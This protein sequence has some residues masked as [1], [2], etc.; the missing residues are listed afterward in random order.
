MSTSW[1]TLAMVKSVKNITDTSQDTAITALL[2]VAEDLVAQ[3]CPKF[4]PRQSFT[5]THDGMGGGTIVLKRRP[6][7]GVVSVKDSM[8]RAF[9]TTTAL[10]SSSYS[11]DHESGVI[12]FDDDTIS[13]DEDDG[14]SASG[15]A[16]GEGNKNVQVVYVAGYGDYNPSNGTDSND[17]ETYDVPQDLVLL[18]ADFIQGS[19]N[20]S[21]T[22][23]KKE[24]RIGDYS[25]VM[26]DVSDLSPT[27]KMTIQRWADGTAAR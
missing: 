20:A 23:G 26:G 22:E 24:E 12:Q 10:D 17:F 14:A 16:L 21:G 9:S 11:V 2:R 7:C 5:E 4:I 1:L 19:Q 13:W 15:G 6:V 3:H 27:S 18:A 25:Y 8:S